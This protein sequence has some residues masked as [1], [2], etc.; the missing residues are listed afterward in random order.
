MLD[1]LP[2]E[3]NRLCQGRAAALLLQTNQIPINMRAINDERHDSVL[4]FRAKPDRRRKV[5]ID[6]LVGII[7]LPEPARPRA[8]YVGIVL[9]LLFY[10][11]IY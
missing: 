9:L 10:T 2:V 1:E 8:H 3:L 7:E 6:E 5:D 4:K 11:F